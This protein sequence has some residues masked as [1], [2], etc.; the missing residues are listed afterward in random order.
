MVWG[1]MR[2]E[3]VSLGDGAAKIAVEEMD[4]EVVV[5]VFVF[6][7]AMCF[8]LL[9]ATDGEARQLWS[10][11]ISASTSP[12]SSILSEV[13]AAAVAAAA[14]AATTES[15]RVTGSGTKTST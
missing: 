1:R 8:K 5:V 10:R 15:L 11:N 13:V 4:E 3:R 12:K 14:A 2:E 7:C 6:V 9:S